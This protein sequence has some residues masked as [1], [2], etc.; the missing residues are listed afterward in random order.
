MALPGAT[1]RA[2][3]MPMSIARHEDERALRKQWKRGDRAARTEAGNAPADTEQR[4]AEGRARDQFAAASAART[5]PREPGAFW[6]PKIS[7]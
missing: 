4:G 2:K 5:Q 6:R 7:L 1:R 3:P